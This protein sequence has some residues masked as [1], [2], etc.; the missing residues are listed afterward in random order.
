MLCRIE[1]AFG[2]SLFQGLGFKG[3]YQ[4]RLEPLRVVHPKAPGCQGVAGWILVQWP[5]WGLNFPLRLLDMLNMTSDGCRV[6]G[7]CNGLLGSRQGVFDEGWGRDYPG[8]ALRGRILGFGGYPRRA[9]RVTN[10]GV[11]EDYPLRA[12]RVTN[13]GVWED[14]PRRALR[15]TNFGRWED[16]P[17][18]ALRVT[19]F[20][21]LAVY[22]TSMVLMRGDSG[23][24]TFFVEVFVWFSGVVRRVVGSC[25]RVWPGWCG[26][27]SVSGVLGRCCPGFWR[28]ALF[29]FA[30]PAAPAAPSAPPPKLGDGLF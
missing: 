17:L 21:R 14:Y 6:G 2:A 3:Q 12:R 4:R 7:Y 10:F 15:V 28:D 8:R 23:I 1:L 20:G 11:W 18:R 9:R 19:K 30:A 22:V 5:V 25:P 26:R 16:Y 27:S 29:Y 13:F 24:A